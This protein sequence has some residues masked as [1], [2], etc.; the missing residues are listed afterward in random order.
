ML[1]KLH[2]YRLTRLQMIYKKAVL[3]SFLT[4][5]KMGGQFD[6]PVLFQKIIFRER[7]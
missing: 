5:K 6:S 3:K 2:T 4:L 7:E 1:K